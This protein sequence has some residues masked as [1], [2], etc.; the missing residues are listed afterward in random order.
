MNDSDKVVYFDGESELSKSEANAAKR[1]L[2][3]FRRMQS[4]FDWLVSNGIE[5]AMVPPKNR[6]NT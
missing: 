2:R 3:A 6:S 4:W 5:P 1:G